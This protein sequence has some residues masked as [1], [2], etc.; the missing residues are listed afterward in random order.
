[1][2][3]STS[4]TD[5]HVHSVLEDMHS[6]LEDVRKHQLQIS[7]TQ[8][9]TMERLL[10]ALKKMVKKQSKMLKEVMIGNRTRQLHYEAT[11]SAIAQ[12]QQQII[13]VLSKFSEDNAFVQLEPVSNLKETLLNAENL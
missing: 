4:S 1:M 9:M 5:D 2:F 6:I 10:K 12:Q 3:L 13:D 8:C 11:L 7:N